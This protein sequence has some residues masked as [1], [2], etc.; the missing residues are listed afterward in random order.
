[1]Q[2]L[3]E[4]WLAS[5]EKW[6]SSSWVVQ[7]ETSSEFSKLGARRWMTFQQISEKYKSAEV[8]QCIV[9]E[10]R[11]NKV[12]AS[13]QIKRHPDCPSRDETKLHH[14][15]FT[16]NTIE[17]LAHGTRTWFTTSFLFQKFFLSIHVFSSFFHDPSPRLSATSGSS[18]LPG[19][20]L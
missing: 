7:M 15:S 9:D 1:M 2:K 13:Q 5:N 16:L 18:P 4:E 3:Y 8:A 11:A 19:L 20:G 10:K 14:K 6:T 17:R 12:L